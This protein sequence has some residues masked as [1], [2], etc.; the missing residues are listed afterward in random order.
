MT[1][2]TLSVALLFLSFSACSPGPS[3]ALGCTEVKYQLERE[4]EQEGALVHLTARGHLRFQAEGYRDLDVQ[5][6][7]RLEGQTE[8]YEVSMRFLWTPE[9]EWLLSGVPG[10]EGFQAYSF[11]PGRMHQLGKKK[12]DVVSLGPQDLD[13]ERLIRKNFPAFRPN[14]FDG[15][16]SPQ[17]AQKESDYSMKSATGDLSIRIIYVKISESRGAESYVPQKEITFLDG[18]TLLQP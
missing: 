17:E 6:S 13:P 14:P 12:G 7:L 18:E 10:Q 9:K 4:L 15:P 8:A 2:A 5:V 11:D 3:P 1:R 16:L